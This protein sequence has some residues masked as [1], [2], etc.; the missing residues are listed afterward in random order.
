M[1]KTLELVFRNETG[2]EV[3]ISLADPKDTL[4]KLE[5]QTVMADIIAKNIFTSKGGNLTEALESR[6]RSRDTQ[7]LV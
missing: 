4:T 3:M 6:V 5:A 1:V 7:A 2:Q